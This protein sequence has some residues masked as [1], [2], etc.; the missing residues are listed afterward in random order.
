MSSFSNYLVLGLCLLAT[1]CGFHPVYATSPATQQNVAGV[2][3]EE[4]SG[5]RRMAQLFKAR[6]EDRLNPDGAVPAQPLYRL[7]VSLSSTEAAIGVARDGTVSRYNV[8]LDSNY[9]LIRNSDGKPFAK[10]KLRHVSS[11][12]N[13]TSVYFSTYVA[14]QDAITRGIAELAE[15]YQQRLSPYLGATGEPPPP[16]LL[17]TPELDTD[18]PVVPNSQPIG[19]VDMQRIFHENRT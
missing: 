16:S 4:V 14:Q 18:L 19:P 7:S 11:Y 1:G 5:E 17:L 3:I 6:L 10:G 2:R 13:P 9:L 8:Y 12:N 15:L